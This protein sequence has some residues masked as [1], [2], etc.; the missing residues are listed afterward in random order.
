MKSALSLVFV[1]KGLRRSPAAVC[2][3]PQHSV[4]IKRGKRGRTASKM[5]D[6][7][8]MDDMDEETTW[9]ICRGSTLFQQNAGSV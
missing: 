1:V 8:R 2:T 7:D 5:D 4:G 3:M 9:S 6:M